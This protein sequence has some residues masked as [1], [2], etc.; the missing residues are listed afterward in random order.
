MY[1]SFECKVFPSKAIHRRLVCGSFEDFARLG[2]VDVFFSAERLAS[3]ER[4]RTLFAPEARPTVRY[5]FTHSEPIISLNF[6]A[7]GVYFLKALL[8]SPDRG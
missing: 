5:Q 3:F 8:F 7:D 6:T 1:N 4:S 2:I